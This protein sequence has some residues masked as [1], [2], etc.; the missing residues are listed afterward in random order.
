MDSQRAKASYMRG[1]DKGKGSEQEGHQD[2]P[3][4]VAEMSGG[5]Y[6]CMHCGGEVD[7]A[8]QSTAYDESDKDDYRDE[9]AH[10]GH[11]PDQKAED[12]SLFMKAIRG[13]R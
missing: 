10:V 3:G 1:M 9:E 2:R 13:R 7:E 5:G 4:H 12:S 11:G 8:G 6:A